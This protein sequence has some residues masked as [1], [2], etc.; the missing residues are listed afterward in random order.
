[1]L[2]TYHFSTLYIEGLNFEAPKEAQCKI[3]LVREARACVCAHARVSVCV[4]LK[5]DQPDS[6]LFFLLP[7]K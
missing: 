7:S 6:K 2:L 1:M 5:D 4:C 3:W